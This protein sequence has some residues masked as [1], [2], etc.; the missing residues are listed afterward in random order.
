M[1]AKP[2]H[3]GSAKP[4]YI[5]PPGEYVCTNKHR[6][7]TLQLPVDVDNNNSAT[8]WRGVAWSGASSQVL[9]SNDH[10]PMAM[11]QSTQSDDVSAAG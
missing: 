3:H 9:C 2:P 5:I 8:R 6:R 10:R 7:I 4:R 1:A 11:T